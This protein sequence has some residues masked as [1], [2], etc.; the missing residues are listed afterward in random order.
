TRSTIHFEFL[1]CAFHLLEKEKNTI[2]WQI[3]AADGILADPLRPLAV[4]F[5][6]KIVMLEPN[7]YMFERLQRNYARNENIRFIQ[8]ALG[9]AC[10]K[11][12]LHAV[13]PDKIAAEHVEKIP[14]EMISVAKLMT[15]TDNQKPDIVL[16]DVEGM[17]GKI[18]QS[19]LESGIR[20][21]II[22]YET[23][24]LPESDKEALAAKLGKEYVQISFGND[25]VAYRTDFFLAYC[26]EL[27]ITHGIPTIYE[28]ALKF[29]V[30][31]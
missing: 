23:R 16:V 10:G 17:D 26:N 14:V 3:G 31:S 2:I 11:M 22:Q 30:K 27:Y 8:A 13:H 6:P 9:S 24:C 20:P 5:D 28:E 18:L 7:P 4:N 12:E 29:I 21:K 19:I 1:K 15:I 25:L